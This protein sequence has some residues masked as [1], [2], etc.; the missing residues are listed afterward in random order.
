[1]VHHKKTPLW[2]WILPIAGLAFFAGATFAGFDENFAASASGI[3]IAVILVPMLVSAVFAAV[4]H[5]EEAAHQTGEPFGTLILTIAVTIIELALIIS[6]LLSGKANATLVRDTVYAVIMIITTGLVGLCIIT[7]GMRFREQTFDVTAAKIYLVVLIVLASLTL[8]LPNYTA[9]VAGPEYSKSQVAFVSLATL[10][11]YGVFL[12]SQTVLYRGYFIS[13]GDDGASSIASLGKLAK[14]ILFLVL[15]LA[16]V[17]LLAKLFSAVVSFAVAAVGAPLP[18]VGVIIALIVLTPESIAA[19]K[20]AKDDNLQK[21]LNLALGSSIATI[22]LTVPAMAIANAVLDKHM[23]LGL[24]ARDVTLLAT[25][26]A[27]S[28]LTFGTGK[29]NVLFGFIHL[30]L[31]AVFM[32]LVFVP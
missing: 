25:A 27:A 20:A 3:L 1:V 31:F 32:F 28:I 17:I 4:Y 16:A 11:L 21:S 26:L 12:Y 9:T 19:V 22:G 8:I 2:T 14:A 30:V 18:V 5:A 15:A 13:S 23:F 7:G 24:E 6:L 10:L 29:T